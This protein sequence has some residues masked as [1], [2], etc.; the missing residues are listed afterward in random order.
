MIE[1]DQEKAGQYRELKNLNAVAGVGYSFS[2]R[3][4]GNMAF[5]YGEMAEVI[6]NR[7]RFLAAVGITLEDV[8]FMRPVHKVNVEVV[9]LK[10][11][12]RGAFEASSAI[13]STDALI[14]T[15]KGVGLALNAA[16]CAPV[17]LTNHR[18]E[19]LAL[20]HAGRE[21]TDLQIGRVVIARLKRMGFRNLDDYVA[22]I[23]PLIGKCC[24]KQQYLQTHTPQLWHDYLRPEGRLPF[25]DVERINDLKPPLYKMKSRDGSNLRLDLAGL[26]WEQLVTAG[27]HPDNISMTSYCT[28]CE[29]EKGLIFSHVVSAR[30]VSTPDAA[31]FPEGRFM[32]VAQLV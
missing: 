5:P 1:S 4:F 23:G 27:I 14:T 28:A 2:P 32:A 12:G 9:G 26:N 10:D 8:V 11:K 24:Y 20:Y 19:F 17:I 6:A 29:A 30:H 31:I 15:E 25:L 7:R 18:A 22:G 21:G 13:P 3:E 16:D